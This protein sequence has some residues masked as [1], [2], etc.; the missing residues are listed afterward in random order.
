[1]VKKRAY[2]VLNR[3]VLNEIELQKNKWGEQ[4]HYPEKWLAILMEEVGEASRATLEAYPVKKQLKSRLFWLKEY[5]EELIQV[6]AVAISAIDSLERNELKR[7]R[8]T[9]K[10]E[11]VYAIV[12]PKGHIRRINFDDHKVWCEFF[13]TNAHQYPIA[14]AIEAYEA[15]GYRLKKFKLI[16]IEEEY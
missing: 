4:N 12:C 1:M 9:M 14:T 6:A 11:N 10:E 13:N 2:T 8:K 15:I 3:D 16:P 5:R 7:E